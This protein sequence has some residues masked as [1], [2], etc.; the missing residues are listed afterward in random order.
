MLFN[1]SITILGNLI[2]LPIKSEFLEGFLCSGCLGNHIE[3]PINFS[4]NVD[5]AYTNEKLY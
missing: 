4:F 3:L 5:P 1:N 2:I